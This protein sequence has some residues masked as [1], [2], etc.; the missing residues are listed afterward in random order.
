MKL[1]KFILSIES[2]IADI[3]A[4]KEIHKP[5]KVWVNIEARKK[6]IVAAYVPGQYIPYLQ[7]VADSLI[8]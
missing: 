6:R 5:R 1:K 8:L 2:D 4:G 7:N 3:Q